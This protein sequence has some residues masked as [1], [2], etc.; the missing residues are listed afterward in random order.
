MGEKRFIVTCYIWQYIILNLLR[1]LSRSLS[2]SGMFLD[3]SAKK[4][5]L[6]QYPLWGLPVHRLLWDPPLPGGAPQLHQVT[7]ASPWSMYPDLWPPPPPPPK[8]IMSHSCPVLSPS[9]DETNV[10]NPFAL[11]SPSCA[12]PRLAR[13]SNTR[14]G[15]SQLPSL[16]IASQEGVKL[17][18]DSVMMENT[19]W[20][21][22]DSRD[23]RKKTPRRTFYLALRNTSTFEKWALCLSCPH[24]DE[25]IDA[26]FICVCIQ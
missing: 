24:P 22:F 6:G 25:K 11:I 13:Y 12:P 5:E 4:P 3:C 19:W 18:D 2:F 20:W 9:G 14:T 10:S 16:S 7:G 26:D 17:N 21:Y 23:Y 15:A 8:P 1:P